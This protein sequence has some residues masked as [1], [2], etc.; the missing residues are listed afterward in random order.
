MM[1][2]KAQL[3]NVIKNL[4]KAWKITFL[5][6]FLSDLT[7]FFCFVSQFNS[8]FPPLDLVCVN[9][10]QPNLTT[11]IDTST[12]SFFSAVFGILCICVFQLALICIS[13]FSIGEYDFYCILVLN[14]L[15]G[16]NKFWLCN[17]KFYKGKTKWRKVEVAAKGRTPDVP[18]YK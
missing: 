15:D 10:V 3:R 9:L 5:F 1:K 4:S 16:S 12:G 13:L 11:R 17:L 8:V 6:Y 2:S 18:Q 7:L 14:I